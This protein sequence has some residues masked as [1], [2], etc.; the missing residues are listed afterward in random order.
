METAQLTGLSRRV[1]LTIL[2]CIAVLLPLFIGEVHLFDWDEINFAEIAREMNITGEYFTVKLNYLPFWEKPPLFFWLQAACMKLFG[3]NEFASRFPNA[4][5][6]MVY[7]VFIYRLG[8][9]FFRDKADAPFAWVLLFMGSILPFFY[10]KS[11][12]ID[13]LF[14][15]FIYAALVQ[16]FFYSQRTQLRSILFAAIFTGLAFLTK[17]PVGILLIGLTAIGFLV[18]KKFRIRLVWWH[19]LLFFVLLGIV[20]SL[21]ILPE[22][23]KGGGSKLFGEFIDYQ[24]RL[25]STS[26]AG[27]GQPFFYHFVVLFFGC[28]PISQLAFPLLLRL[29]PKFIREPRDKDF[30]ALN[31]VLFWVVLIVFSITTTKIIHYSS[32]CYLPL[33]FIALTYLTKL[34]GTGF[35]IPRWQWIMT[36]VVALIW[37]LLIILIPLFIYYRPL[38]LPLVKDPFAVGNFML[39]V[40]WSGWEILVGILY[41]AVIV[42][43][44]VNLRRKIRSV[45]LILSANILLLMSVLIFILPKIEQHVQGSYISFLERHRGDDYVMTFQF[46][47][48]AHLFYTKKQPV[49]NPLSYDENWL[50]TGDIDKPVYIVSKIQRKEEL[51]AIPGVKYLYE[52]GGFVFAVRAPKK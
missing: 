17:G 33:S 16:L 48:Y 6:G 50:L 44:C 7:L 23:I 25:L 38:L 3:V 9:N 41:L 35:R 26:E 32:L 30:Y 46:K 1:Q 19:I 10:F 39:D 34:S 42:Y 8:R 52:R 11:G 5:I 13:P 12:I 45:V 27:H 49:R 28:F 20:G 47:S 4:L 18:Y 24:V 37:S 51:L 2:A 14:N 22:M 40:H 43:A 36:L 21:W 15:L 29:R 31:F